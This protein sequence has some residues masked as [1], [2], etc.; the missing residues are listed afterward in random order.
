MQ[1]GT[2]KSFFSCASFWGALQN[3]QKSPTGLPEFHAVSFKYSLQTLMRILCFEN[4]CLY[5]NFVADG[6]GNGHIQ[7]GAEE[8]AGGGSRPVV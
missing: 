2:V 1:A 3:K 8:H 5:I 4:R 6:T 7:T